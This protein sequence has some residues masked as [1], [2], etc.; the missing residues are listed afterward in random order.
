MSFKDKRTRV[1]AAI[2]IAVLLAFAVPPFINLN[3]FRSILSDSLSRS[4][5]RQ[6][7]VQDVRL[8][9]LPLP[10]FT[11][12]QL[13]IS[14]DDFSA[15]PILQTGGEAGVATLRLTSLWRGRLEIASISLTQA[16]LNLVRKPDGHWNIE[17]LIN[18]A[19]QVPSAPTSKKKPETRA[20]FP[21]IEI[22]ESR[23]N[24]KFGPE[25]KPFALADAEFAL[26]L[27]AENRWNV[28]LKAIPLR[29]DQ[30]VSDTGV[31]KVSGS[32]DRAAQFS[33]TPFHLQVSWQHPEVNAI[34]HIVRGHDPGWRGYADLIA[35]LKGTPADF[36]AKLEAGIDEFRRY[37]IA[38]NSS[39]DVRVSCDQRFRAE[40]PDDPAAN[41]LDFNCKAPFNSGMLTAL[42][43][44]SHL[45]NAPEYSVRLVANDLPVSRLVRGLLH[46]KSTLPDDLSGEGSINGSWLIAGGPGLPV[47]WSGQ[48][49]ATNA[50]LR[51]RELQM[52]LVFPPAVT[53]AFDPADAR[54]FKSQEPSVSRA[55]LQPF[56]VDLGGDAGI[57]GTFTPDGYRFEVNGPVEWQRLLQV[58]RAIGLHPPQTDLRG[59][60]LLTAQYAGEW[61]HFAAPAVSAQAQVRSATLSLPGFSEPLRLTAGKLTL[62]G[63]GFRAEQVSASFPKRQL[64]FSGNLSG[65]RQCERHI[66]C[67][68]IFFFQADELKEASLRELLTI[69]N[70]GIGLPFFN[71]S[72]QFQANWLLDV[73]SRGSV[74]VRRLSV[75]NLRAAN[76]TAQ[77]QLGA[78]KALVRQWTGD[79]LGGKYTGE[80]ALDSSGPQFSI[81]SAGSIQGIRLE[82]VN[83]ALDQRIGAG[84]FDCNYQL[85]M[86]GADA[87]QMA[88]SILG[89]GI[90]T[91]HNGSVEGAPDG[92]GAESQP[93]AFTSWSGKFL[94][95]KQRIAFERTTMVSASGAREIN[96][97]A[98]FE[99]QW[100]LKLVG[101]GAERNVASAPG[102]AVAPSSQ[103][104]KL[105][106]SR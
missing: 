74:S 98:A 106:Q 95:A 52:P 35:E 26:W 73:S 14:D 3:H 89:S 85:R 15:E 90:F 41:Q 61:R 32:F 44:L 63:A 10:G 83:A 17:R 28:R 5:G 2:A 57:S 47:A 88:K 7:S 70:S 86:A 103:Q 4:L 79:V 8:R 92:A 29:A 76:V 68:L 91:W 37:D 21:Y 56:I 101:A 65:A 66:L 31:I 11:F 34:T 39:F 13:R 42:G 16:S 62:D 45:G 78:G 75:Q 18:R 97:E 46:A 72:R 36:S 40:G 80:M 82:Q 84:T 60:G 30:N 25:K 100:R 48:L 53:V 12:R 104:A 49:T 94:I 71:P 20:R 43:S 96:G 19:A 9:L 6:V 58:A 23:I 69:P 24:F 54:A 55:F 22:T 67:D 87:A 1:Y 105:D 38:R 51:S 27:A 81:T 50:M 99:R 64:E 102:A 93:L 33:E 59:T 77:L